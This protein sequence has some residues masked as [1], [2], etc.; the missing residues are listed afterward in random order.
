M[1][2][3]VR[4]IVAD[5]LSLERQRT[6]GLL[7]EI[8]EQRRRATGTADAVVFEFTRFANELVDPAR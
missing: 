3:R 4:H 1:D 6:A 8:A 7:L 2:D 5:A